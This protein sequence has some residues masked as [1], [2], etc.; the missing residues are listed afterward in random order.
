MGDLGEFNLGVR[1]F[2]KA[3]R[4]R[5]IDPVPWTPIRKPLCE[6]RV[7]LVSTAGLSLPEQPPFDSTVRGGD[8]SYREIPHDTDLAVL[9]D[10]H[11]SESFD[12]SGIHRDPNLA[13]PADRLREL[14]SAGRLGSINQRHLSFARSPSASDRPA[15]WPSP[16]STVTL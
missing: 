12:H 8:F 3:Y 13:L 4:W 2:L 14:Q 7:A 15:P 6:C 11:R 16:S 9:R 10:D 5:R 1:L